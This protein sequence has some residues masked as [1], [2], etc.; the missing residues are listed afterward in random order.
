LIDR[1]PGWQ[2]HRVGRV[3]IDIGIDCPVAGQQQQ[4]VS[5]RCRTDMA[6]HGERLELS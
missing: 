6:R 5:T 4:R 1:H 2:H 3:D